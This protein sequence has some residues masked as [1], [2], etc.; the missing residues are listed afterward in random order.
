MKAVLKA[1]PGPGAEL[2]QVE[3]PRP[4]P[5]EVLVKVKAASICGTDYHI[6]RWDPWSAGRVK[7]PLVL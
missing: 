2:C 7:P 5:G 6:Y 1:A 3:V 4:G